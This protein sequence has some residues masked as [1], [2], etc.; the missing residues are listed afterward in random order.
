MSAECSQAQN[1]HSNEPKHVLRPCLYCRWY[2][3]ISSLVFLHIY[4]SFRTLFVVDFK[5]RKDMELNANCN[6]VETSGARPVQTRSV[7]TRPQ[8]KYK[9]M[10]HLWEFLLELLADERCKS[11]ICWTR[12][13]EG[14][15]QLLNHHE[16]AKRWGMFKPRGGMDYGK[17]SRALRLY[18]REGIIT[19]VIFDILIAF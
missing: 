6:T 18:Y 17:L 5:L 12:E 3:H 16:V 2:I 4:A 11:I 15:F 14:E 8:H 1:K 10:L 7:P 9:N 13:D 19:K